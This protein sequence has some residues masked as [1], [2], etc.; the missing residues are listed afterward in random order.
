[1]S[2]LNYIKVVLTV[3][4]L[5]AIGI[6]ALIY[7]LGTAPPG[8]SG[9]LGLN[10]FQNLPNTDIKTIQDQTV[11]GFTNQTTTPLANIGSLIFVSGFVLTNLL[12]NFVLAVPSMVN[13]LLQVIFML[14]PIDSRLQ[15]LAV[16]FFA[17]GI[18]IIYV[19]GL[20]AMFTS[21]STGRVI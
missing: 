17:A 5:Y 6:T 18:T 19:L 4:I 16:V 21:V 2:M 3:Q 9:N 15:G 8:I 12:A 13:I 10:I 1:M 11:G 7:A 20:I 14:I